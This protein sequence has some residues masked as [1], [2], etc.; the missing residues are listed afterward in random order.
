MAPREEYGE[1]G[2]PRGTKGRVVRR[3]CDVAPREECG[4]EG[5]LYQGDA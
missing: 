1:E 3:A 5:V 2:M 4:E